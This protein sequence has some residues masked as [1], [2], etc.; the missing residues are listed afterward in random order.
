M[1]GKVLIGLGLIVVLLLLRLLLSALGPAPNDVDQIQA[2]IEEARIGAEAGE[3]NRITDSIAEN[4]VVQGMTRRELVRLMR[5]SLRQAEN[6]RVT[7]SRPSVRVEGDKATAQIDKASVSYTW[8]GMD[9]SLGLTGLTL[10]L[11][12]QKVRKW[13]VFTESRWQI[14]RATASGAPSMGG[15]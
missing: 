10:H 11:E 14:V 1:K 4:A 7:L 6:I 13:L 9:T 8:N 15:F 12:R 3:P 5:A 2:L